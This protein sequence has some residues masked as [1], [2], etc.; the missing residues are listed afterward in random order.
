MSPEDIA[1]L[2]DAGIESIEQFYEIAKHPDS[3]AELSEKI[4]V[5]GFTLEGWSATAGNYILM[6][7]CEWD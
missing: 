1:K 6:M 7:N 4:G 3:R 5:D 2:K